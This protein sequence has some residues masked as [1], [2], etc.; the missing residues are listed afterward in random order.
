[1]STINERVAAL[2]K[3][4]NLT[5]EE[6]GEQIGIKKSAVSK[7]ENGTNN[8]T[9]SLVKLMVRTFHVDPVWLECG[10]GQMFDEGLTDEKIDRIFM[11]SDP[12]TRTW[13]KAL[14]KLSDADWNYFKAQLEKVESIRNGRT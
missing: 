10:E 4:L 7:L 6:F 1:M 12:F 14:A 3:G 8:V 5:Q 13:M 9:D 11:D 2:R